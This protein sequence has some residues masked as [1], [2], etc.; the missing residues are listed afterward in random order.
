MLRLL[1]GL[2]TS[3]VRSLHTAALPS[4]PGD[5]HYSEKLSLLN[6]E[7]NGLTMDAKRTLIRNIFSRF[8]FL[9]YNICHTALLLLAS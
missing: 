9:R 5:V 1:R 3:L 2:Q 7:H 6:V 8:L 4:V